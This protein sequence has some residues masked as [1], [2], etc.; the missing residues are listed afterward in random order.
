M[1]GGTVGRR[2]LGERAELILALELNGQMR[3][4]MRSGCGGERSDGFHAPG[5]LS[6]LRVACLAA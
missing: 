6:I 4:L 5:I 1:R 2:L 3:V